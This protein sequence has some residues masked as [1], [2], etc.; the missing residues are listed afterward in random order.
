M[1]L[2]N[3]EVVYDVED[4]LYLNFRYRKPQESVLILGYWSNTYLCSFFWSKLKQHYKQITVKSN[5]TTH[6]TREKVIENMNYSSN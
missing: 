5:I 6:I 3:Q 2:P 1:K 4:R